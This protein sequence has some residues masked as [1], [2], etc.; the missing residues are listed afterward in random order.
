[1]KREID[2]LRMS[3]IKNNIFA[4]KM[5]WKLSKSTIIHACISSALDYFEWIFF[6]A[7]FMRY[8]IN[9]IEEKKSFQYILNFIIITCI[10]FVSIALYRSYINNV[11]M[12]LNSTTI[13]KGLYEK[14][15]KK[16]RNVELSCFENPEFYNKYTMAIDG[17]GDKITSVI[18]NVWG[19][20]TGAIATLIV[21]YTMFSIDNMAVLFVIFPIIGNFVFG[22]IMNKLELK[23]YEDNIPNERV[24]QYVNRVMYLAEYA[25]EIRLSKIYKLIIRKYNKAVEGTV[26]IAG[27]YAP[28]IVPVN[29][30]KNIFTFTIIFEGVLLY[31][32]YKAMIVK[33]I[34][35]SQM[36]VL[37][38]IMV[39]STWILI[40]LF[41]SIL[42]TMKNGL[43]VKNLRVFMEYKEAI[44]E[45]WEGIIPKP[46]ISSIEFRNVS[47][48]YKDNEYIVKNLNFKIEGNS[49]A[50]LVGHNGAG[51]STII[52]LL[53]RL[54]DPTNGD[55]FVNGKNIKEYNLRAY[56]KLF[57]A[58]F[59]DY[60][61]LALSIKENVLM[62][63]ECENEDEAVIEA[64]KKAGIYEK[65]D[66]LPKGID[67]ILTKE[68]DESGAVLSGGQYQKIAV[69]RTFVQDAPIK[70]YDEPSSAL[71][72]IAEYELY[73]SI[74]KE[75]K[76]KTMIFISHRLS[77]VRNADKVFMLEN[78]EIIEQGTHEELME[79][80]G[81]Y[82]DMYTKQAMNYL[83]LNSIEG[84]EL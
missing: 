82:A 70:V 80:K 75:S 19:V 48:A 59:Q 53:F 60:K 49:I 42:E 32:A 31:G 29:I 76:N 23:R 9:G 79:M 63:H 68:F 30:L 71:D 18:K 73:K 55:I 28:K 39:S 10:L 2:T 81:S 78:G 57:T 3:T 17:A 56:R 84:V 74:M 11:T 26:S 36:A 24:S 65:V 12:Q 6:S 83:A 45:D 8:I 35:L 72:P 4:M 38:S 21:F 52:K 41:N 50:A 14:L 33:S 51:K 25:K 1:M 13:Y 16:A 7:V 58:A 27:N 20:V 47:F 37:S 77:S 44:P 34:S 5:G 40:G 61:V 64:L 43:F 62:E 15:Y 69:A 54:Y 22:G 67:T 46:F 66:T